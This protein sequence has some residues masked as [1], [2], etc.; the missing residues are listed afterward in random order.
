MSAG[1]IFI[2]GLN[3]RQ[4]KVKHTGRPGCEKKS[5]EKDRCKKEIK[6]I[7]EREREVLPGSN[8]GSGL[9]IIQNEERR[10]SI[11]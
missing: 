2:S 9:F 6:K 5:K 11:Q 4:R 8:G 3:T 7:T 10:S 1:S